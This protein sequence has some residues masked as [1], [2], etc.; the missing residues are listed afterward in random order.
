MSDSSDIE[1][2]RLREEIAILLDDALRVASETVR[3]TERVQHA[4]DDDLAAVQKTHDGEMAGA[5]HVYDEDLEQ[6]QRVHNGEMADLRHER[7]DDLANM[8]AALGSRDVI[9]QAKGIIM[10]TMHCSAERAFGLLRA[11]SQAENRKIVD[12]AIEIAE[13]AARFTT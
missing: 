7:D 13:R 6:M 5:Q 9:G 1:I 8:Q 2:G 3:E 10:A 12:I 4:H 11:Q